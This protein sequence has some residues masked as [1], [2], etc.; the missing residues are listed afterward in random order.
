[1]RSMTRYRM[2]IGVLLLLGLLLAAC[3]PAPETQD[4]APE[5]TAAPAEP[6]SEAPPQA[7]AAAEEAAAEEAA[8][9][10]NDA[11]TGELLVGVWS[12]KLQTPAGY[13]YPSEWEFKDDG[14]LLLRVVTD[15]GTINMAFAYYFDPDGALR[16]DS[17]DGSEPGRREVFFENDDRVRLVAVRD[18]IVTLL[19]R[20]PLQ[21]EES[22]LPQALADL[23]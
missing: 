15:E 17:Q 7:K 23:R 1:M 8:A 5:A 20:E 3:Q 9:E 21:I 18:G 12:G 2:L 11:G 22:A 14:V 6:E 19:V 10:T 4:A 16:L 13:V